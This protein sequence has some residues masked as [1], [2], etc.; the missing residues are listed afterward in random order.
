MLLFFFFGESKLF[1]IE[2]SDFL[3]MYL[4]IIERDFKNINRVVIG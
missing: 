4:I 3:L 2:V 1:K